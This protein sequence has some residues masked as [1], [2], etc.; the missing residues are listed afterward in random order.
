MADV[1][2]QDTAAV[3]GRAMTDLQ[4]VWLPPGTVVEFLD[5]ASIDVS[6]FDQ[7]E[8]WVYYLEAIGDLSDAV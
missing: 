5:W 4:S 3:N 7:A 2:T 8:M 6:G 1:L